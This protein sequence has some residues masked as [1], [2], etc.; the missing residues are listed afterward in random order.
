[1]KGSTVKVGTRGSALALAQSTQIIRR[2][3]E[4]HPKL[5]FVLVPIKTAGDRITSAA[6]LRKAGK[7]LFVK[8]I[9]RALIGRRISMAIHSMKDLPSELPDGL[10]IGAVPARADASDVFIGRNST[11]IEKL[12]PGAQVGTSSLRRQAILKSIFPH[13]SFVELKGNLDT[14]L[15]KLRAPRSALSGIVVAAAGVGRLYPE[16]GIPTQPLPMEVLVPA[17]GQGAIAIEIRGRDEEMRKLLQPIHHESTAACVDA[18]REFQRRLEGGCQVPMGA[19][20]EASDDGLLRLTACLA[21]LD[22][23]RII[24]ESQTGTLDNPLAIA[25]ALETVVNS[26]GAQEILSA[27]RPPPARPAQSARPHRNGRAMRPNRRGSSRPKVRARI[28]RR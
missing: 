2:L 7:G 12:P 17:A 27:L 22:G 24:R 14:R 13:L 20:A 15:E 19:H 3:K 26:K 11:P 18:E 8:E 23:R 25:A 10:A 28:R 1:M 5:N 6:E 4:I 9:E 21:S 16:N